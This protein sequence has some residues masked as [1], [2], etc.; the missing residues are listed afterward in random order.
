MMPAIAKPIPPSVARSGRF[1][2]VD[3]GLGWGSGPA[4]GLAVVSV[5]A[6]GSIDRRPTFGPPVAIEDPP[7]ELHTAL[8]YF[9]GALQNP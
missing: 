1:P 8:H 9:V 5:I 7:P 2:G 3:L 4:G 6:M